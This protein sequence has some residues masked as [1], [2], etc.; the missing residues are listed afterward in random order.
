MKDDGTGA[1]RITR[2]GTDRGRGSSQTHG[3]SDASGVDAAPDGDEI[4]PDT[5]AAPP[6]ATHGRG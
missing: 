4:H 1:T 5:T 3:A 6:S 2:D